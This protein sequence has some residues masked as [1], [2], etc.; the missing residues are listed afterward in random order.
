MRRKK[1]EVEKKEN[2]ALNKLRK[3]S[4]LVLFREDFSFY[5]SA[6]G[7]RSTILPSAIKWLYAHK[8]RI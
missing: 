6:S 4:S 5:P 3:L 7:Q 8:I 1:E 2:Y